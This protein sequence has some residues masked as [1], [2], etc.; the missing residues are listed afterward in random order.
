MR[1]QREAQV[2]AEARGRARAVRPGS[3]PR[4]GATRTGA[5]WVGS[6]RTDGRQGITGWKTVLGTRHSNSQLHIVELCIRHKAISHILLPELPKYIL[7]LYQVCNI[8]SNVV[9]YIDLSAGG[10]QI[11][12][13][14]CEIHETKLEHC[15][16]IHKGTLYLV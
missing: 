3:V 11:Y 16:G 4:A 12:H 8:E 7:T 15:I 5:A 1:L 10:S 6:V 14:W 9:E 13:L 2:W